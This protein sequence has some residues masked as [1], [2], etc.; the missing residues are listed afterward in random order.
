MRLGRERGRLVI[1]GTAGLGRVVGAGLMAGG[2]YCLAA[3]LGVPGAFGVSPFASGVVA[4][5]LGG[6]VV[7]AG[8]WVLWRTRRSSVVVDHVTRTVTLINRGF[9]DT[10]AVEYPRSAVTDGRVTKERDGKGAP[11]YRVELVLDTGS[12]VPVPLFRPHDRARC[13]RAAERLW[14]ALGGPHRPAGRLG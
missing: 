13:M 11:V 10:T 4:A 3:A 7:A 6:L 5:S 14:H 2:G 1:R 9:F 8:V 12:V